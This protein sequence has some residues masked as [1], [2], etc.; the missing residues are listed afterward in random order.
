MADFQV[1]G[2]L[3]QS[4]HLNRGNRTGRIHQAI[5]RLQESQP[6]PRLGLQDHGI[7]IQHA[8]ANPA[9]QK[10]RSLSGVQDDGTQ[11]LGGIA[12]ET[13]PHPAPNQRS[14]ARHMRRGH[15][16]ATQRGVAVANVATDDVGAWC[17]DLHR[18]DPVV[19]VV[20]QFFRGRGGSNTESSFVVAR[21]CRDEVVAAAHVSC[22]SYEEMSA[23]F[24]TLHCRFQRQAVRCPTPTVGGDHCTHGHRIVQRK[25]RIAGATSLAGQETKCHDSNGRTASECTHDALAVLHRADDA[26]AVGPVTI[27]I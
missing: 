24:G 3:T 27:V 15:G 18:V 5:R 16:S 19:A 22:C 9:V 11:V 4:I 20:R 2:D 12:H 10:R 17:S 14:G 7:H 13:L 6:V 23:L 26:H 8:M 25:H 1:R 21:E